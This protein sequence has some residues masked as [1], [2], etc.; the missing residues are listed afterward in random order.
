M[1]ND[2]L[3]VPLI[4]EHWDAFDIGT[5][6]WEVRN[7][8]GNFAPKFV[9]LDRKVELRKG[10]SKGNSIWGEIHDVAVFDTVED[11]LEQVPFHRILPNARSKREAVKIITDL[12]GT[13]H[14]KIAFRPQL[15]PPPKS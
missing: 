2:R 15:T 1:K 9:R 12:L 11:V 14:K 3:F 7:A 13:E 6:G 5:K 4:T 8:V 10:Y